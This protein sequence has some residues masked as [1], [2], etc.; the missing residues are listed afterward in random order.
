M[1]TRNV[2]RGSG[3]TDHPS[4]QPCPKPKKSKSDPP[5]YMGMEGRLG[6]KQKAA[7][8]GLIVL[9]RSL[10]PEL[11]AGVV[12][13]YGTYACSDWRVTEIS[14]SFGKRYGEAFERSNPECLGL[15]AACEDY[16][17][18]FHTK[19]TRPEGWEEDLDL[20]S[21]AEYM[22]R[23]Q[24]E[25]GKKKEAL[26]RSL[27][28]AQ[29]LVMAVTRGTGLLP[30]VLA[31]DPEGNEFRFLGEV[32]VDVPAP[33]HTHRLSSDPPADRVVILWPR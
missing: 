33:A 15:C 32:Q 24:W 31:A 8:D 27:K 29:E 23:A 19:P 14:F 6:P 18:E 20:K 17:R 3:N 11:T 7:M 10:R 12:A 26:P 13:V 16:L 2:E 22:V 1:A 4:S 30:V 21:D 28:T 25:A 5:I 9:L